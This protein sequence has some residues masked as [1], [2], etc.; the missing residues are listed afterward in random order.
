MKKILALIAVAVVS[1]ATLTA[2][3]TSAPAEKTYS[4]GVAS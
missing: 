4:F 1:L 2:C 3:G